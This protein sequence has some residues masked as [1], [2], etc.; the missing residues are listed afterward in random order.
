[1]KSMLCMAFLMTFSLV[2]TP[3]I[4]EE[5]GEL[6]VHFKNINVQNKGDIYIALY[7]KEEDFMSRNFF[8]STVTQVQ[9]DNFV[10]HFK[11]IPFGT[12]AISAFHDL[13]GNGQLDF[14]ENGMPLEDYA[15]SGKA[16]Q[17]GPPT[18]Q[19]VK[20]EF[21]KDQQTINVYF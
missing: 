21:S 13:N 11:N 4:V 19:S 2:E 5:Q 20:F 1:M 10:V 14:N 12:Y 15:M 8:K 17:M 7:N 16:E 9:K 6:N 18:W 3:K